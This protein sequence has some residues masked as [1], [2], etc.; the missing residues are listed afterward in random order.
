MAAQ[1]LG[2]VS[3]PQESTGDS[4]PARSSALEALGC[5]DVKDCGHHEDW[6][7]EVRNTDT[8]GRVTC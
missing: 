8:R 3:R 2:A 7:D 4:Q 5:K 6:M 1:R